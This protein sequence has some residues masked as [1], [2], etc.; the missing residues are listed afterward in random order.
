MAFFR[1][2]LLFVCCEASNAYRILAYEPSAGHSHW[3]VMS[4]VLE[5]MVDAGH[6]VV[7]VTLHPAT[8]HLAA[9]P[10]Y[11]HVDI[12][13]TAAGRQKAMTA[14]DRD[15]TGVMRLFGSNGFMIGFAT[16]RARRLCATS[17]GTPEV[18]AILDGSDG[19]DGGGRRPFDA[20]VVESLFS[21]CRWPMW[22]PDR[23]RL[24]VAYV[25]PSAPVN[26][27]PV[28][29]GSPDH[30]SYLGTLLTGHPTPDTFVRR[31]SNTVDYAYTNLVRWYHDDP[32]RGGGWSTTPNAVVFVNTHR[33]VEPARPLGPNVVEI[34]GI[35]LRRPLKPLPQVSVTLSPSLSLSRY[36][37]F[38]PNLLSYTCNQCRIYV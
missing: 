14:V 2:T 16:D 22:L 31:L 1:V 6:E 11:T 9:H 4:A 8:D 38:T 10:N 13:A 25:V 23:S 33:S 21:E 32:Y 30:P 24:P 17:S 7:C 29:T 37:P 18:R 26:W 5:S 27:M 12:S 19:V 20:V 15:F 34:G 36:G 3:N 28:A 35:H